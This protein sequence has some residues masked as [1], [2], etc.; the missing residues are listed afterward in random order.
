ML[1]RGVVNSGAVISGSG[2]ATVNF[3][4]ND[5]NYFFTRDGLTG[6][7]GVQ[8]LGAN[9]VVNHMGTG[10]T[11]ITADNSY[12]G[13]TTITNGTL[14]VGNGGTSGTLGSGNVVNNSS[15]IFNRSNALTFANVISGTGA[16][17]Q[18]GSGTLTLSG[19]NTYS[20][21][22][23][24]NDGTLS[25]SADNHLGNA[26]ALTFNGGA[27][28][29]TSS[30]STSRATT[31]NASGGTFNTDVGTTLTH[32]GAISGSGT[33][34][35]TGTGTL[36]LSTGNS[37]SGG[38]V[39]SQGT[40]KLIN[41]ATN[42]AGNINNNAMLELNVSNSGF[43]F[44]YYD[45]ISGT[46]GLV[47]T[48]PGDMHL[49]GNNTYSGGTTISGGSLVLGTDGSIV[50]NVDN[51]GALRF[52]SS[53][54]YTF[55]G[56]ISGTGSLGNYTS[57]TLTLTG[58]NTYSGNT[59]SNGR[60]QIGNGG[61]SGTLGTG[62]VTNNNALIFNRSDASSYAGDISGT[63]AVSQNGSG[64][65]T[66]SG[67]NTYSGAT[68]VNA[69]TLSI[70][71]SIAN[72]TTT[73]NTSG[74]LGGTGT[75][76]SVNVNGGIFAPGNSIGTS[77]VAG[78]I[79]FTGGGRYNVE[80]NAA[81]ASDLINATGS[82]TLTSGVVNVQP[83]AGTYNI[84]TNYTILTA[85]GGL[86]GTT[87]GSVNS[88]LAF[89]T[90]SLSYD[91]N[92]V[93]LRLTRN[94]VS[95]SNVASTPNQ[96]AVSTM[97][98]SNSTA[99]QSILN[100]IL[101]LTNLGAQR[102]FDS[103]SG[104]QHT[105]NQV[106]MNKVG[107]QFQRLLFNH[108]RQSG[109]DGVG[110]SMQSMPYQVA[111]N[112]NNWQ[113][114]GGESASGQPNWWM[115]GIGNFGSIDDTNNASGADY[116]S[117][118]VAFGVDAVWHDL[119]VGVAGSYVRSDVDSFAGRGDVD[120]FQAAVY[121]RWARDNL[122][123]NAVVN[124]VVNAGLHKV[125]ATRTVTVGSAVSEASADYDNVNMGA[126]I[127]LG[128]NIQLGLKTTVSPY[129]GISYSHNTRDDFVEAGA[130]IAN[131]S[132]N[133]QDEESLRTTL[134]LRLSGDIETNHHKTITPV[135]SIAYVHE[136]LDRVSQL[137]AGFTTVPTS[138]FRVDG[139]H[140]NRDRLQVGLGLAGQLNESTTLN[141]G[142]NG[143]LS[144]TDDHHSFTATIKFL[145]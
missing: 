26:G 92:N 34:A 5:G 128:K 29:T 95:F 80:V 84:V 54:D 87:F 143:E 120:S 119:M 21:G 124:A 10:K 7:A 41:F 91:A 131:L 32:S 78:N 24:I 141:V 33:L 16:L 127:E 108:S 19:A 77:N 40:L 67:T 83:E 60:L 50:G 68:T 23:N 86:G 47:V 61:T 45:V 114:N 12:E 109:N 100:D 28:Q 9:L 66:L 46:G 15:I 31:L 38:A 97:L 18:A 13:G 94:D 14:Q 53:S 135:A 57:R 142:Y 134:G 107:Q 52:A 115:Q 93:F 103:L 104:I 49:R 70:N 140:L 8:L 25:I 76:G 6:G 62:N 88:N 85:A 17:T 3:N 144:G 101:P 35:K 96:I 112:S 63:G 99:L 113:R 1:L 56:D 82:A 111:D 121:G 22:T 11:T 20:G 69:G 145:M 73:V 59:T 90:P 51:N 27:L 39:V 137:Q 75:V 138:N 106:V 4:H 122:F 132:V 58:T 129:V 123:M 44:L 55:A 118:G 37:F 130:G 116:E 48:G 36:V 81:G 139:S 133:K 110:L 79:D 74:T 2:T 98:D 72:S 30:F 64:T 136:H 65:F 117:S 42:T 126:A 125:D 89:L 105:Q 102:A 71:G 43:G